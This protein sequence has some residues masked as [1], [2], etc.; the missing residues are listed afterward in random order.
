MLPP[1]YTCRWSD[2]WSASGHH[3]RKYCWLLDSILH[4]F[5]DPNLP[6][7]QMF[8]CPSIKR[9]S[10]SF[11]D[12]HTTWAHVSNDKDHGILLNMYKSTQ[13]FMSCYVTIFIGGHRLLLYACSVVL[14]TTKLAS[15]TYNFGKRVF[16]PHGNIKTMGTVHCIWCSWC[17]F[18]FSIQFNIQ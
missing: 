2:Y 16:C 10:W 5:W 17:V 13:I 7:Q 9:E 11:L 6:L 4:S 18:I 3:C 8:G 1:F 12:V 15:F 14:Y